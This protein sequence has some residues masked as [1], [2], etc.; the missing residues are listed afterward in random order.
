MWGKHRQKIQER[1]YRSILAGPIVRSRNR[2][3]AEYMKRKAIADLRNLRIRH[4]YLVQAIQALEN[5]QRLR[6]VKDQENEMA[7]L[8]R[9]QSGRRSGCS[10]LLRFA[11]A[12]HLAD[13]NLEVYR[14][15]R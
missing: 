10:G 9:A 12:H 5:F 8:L 15:D 11:T 1:T 2:P 4:K 3:Y 14:A 13:T 7:K 6:S